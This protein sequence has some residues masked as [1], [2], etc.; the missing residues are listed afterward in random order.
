MARTLVTVDGLVVKYQRWGESIA[1]VADLSLAIEEGEWMMVVGHNGSGKST[2]L[3]V[4]AGHIA[5][6][7]GR[8]VFHGCDPSGTKVAADQPGFL[9]DQ[10][11]IASAAAGLTLAENL[12]VA[13][14]ARTG[15]SHRDSEARH[16]ALL[17]SVGLERHGNRLA[18]YLSGGERQ[19]LA[20]LIAH[21]RPSPLV[22][23]D[24]PLAA[25]DAVRH[26][27]CLQLIGQMRGGGK[28]IV[29]VT[30]DH[31]LADLH[32]DRVVEMAG[33]RIRSVK[34]RQATARAEE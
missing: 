23:L 13:D 9:L 29:Q 5:P 22:L 11:P 18:G 6:S 16:A 17:A 20:F 14:S 26:R 30:H 1:A 15:E 33:G 8:V 19:L 12:R 4:L 7:A 25:L 2:L 27:Q 3:R 21:L 32:G 31:Q 24:E 10:D 28:T 34:T